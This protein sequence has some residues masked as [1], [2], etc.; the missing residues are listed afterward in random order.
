[1]H[2]KIKE[3]AYEHQKQAWQNVRS[4]DLLAHSTGTG[5]TL[6]AI[7]LCVE[8][9]DSATVVVPLSVLDKWVD[10]FHNWCEDAETKE[11]NDRWRM[12]EADGTRFFIVTKEWFRDNLDEVPGMESI[13]IDEAHHFSGMSSKMSKAAI[14]YV[15]GFEIDYRWLLTATPYRSTPWNVYRLAQILGYD[16]SYPQ[17]ERKYFTPQ[18]FGERKVMTPKDNIEEDMAKLVDYI[19]HV[20]DIED[21]IDMPDQIHQ[22]E[23]VSLTDQQK[24]AI[25]EVHMEDINPMVK[26]TK[27]HG[28]ESGFQKGDEYNDDE[29]YKNYKIDRV[30]DYV[31]SADKVAVICR[32]VDQIA[33][34]EDKIQTQKDIYTIHGQDKRREET[35]E[36]VQE[37]DKAVVIISAGV[38]EGYEMPDINL[39]VFAS[40]GFGLVEWKQITGRINRMNKPTKNVYKYL[41]ATREGD[42]ESVDEA[43]YDKVVNEKADFDMAIYSREREGGDFEEV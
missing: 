30:N 37:K 3:A 2:D 41:L 10:E 1:M 24:Q 5:K 20:I 31:D 21:V 39:M 40:M 12:V 9:V 4:R 29:I 8:R 22:V 6:T 36:E 11:T 26:Y 13:V 17:F 34:M 15:K 43:V 27:I 14:K 32:Y 16:W 18:Y 42:K 19:G 28:I 7:G 33:Y 23:K 25:E 35:I 38:S